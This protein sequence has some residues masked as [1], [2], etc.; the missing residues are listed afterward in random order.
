MKKK[1]SRQS[2]DA[3]NYHID[4]ADRLAALRLRCGADCCCRAGRLLLAIEDI[5]ILNGRCQRRLAGTKR[6]WIFP[7]R[8]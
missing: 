1:L 6:P 7:S 2:E 4:F 5:Q 8:R 3:E